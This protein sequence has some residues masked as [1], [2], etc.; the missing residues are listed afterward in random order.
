[1]T[2]LT[3]AVHVTDIHELNYWET[4]SSNYTW[5]RNLAQMR[6]YR[7]SAPTLSV[8]S[9]AGPLNHALQT[10]R[11][12]NINNKEL[13]EELSKCSKGKRQTREY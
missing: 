1:M 5:D 12:R 4:T 9:T 2:N 3:S 13:V 11:A 8:T 6:A 7:P 10:I